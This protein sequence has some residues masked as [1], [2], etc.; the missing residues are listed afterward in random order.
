MI[1]LLRQNNK[2]HKK[3]NVEKIGDDLRRYFMIS[4]I[5]SDFRESLRNI[6]IFVKLCRNRKLLEKSLNAWDKHLHIFQ[7]KFEIF[8]I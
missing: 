8:T 3:I 5:V 1:K 2:V 4:R 7:H 6:L